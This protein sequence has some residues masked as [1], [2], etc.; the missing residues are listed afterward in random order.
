MPGHDDGDRSDNEN[1]D[2]LRLGMGIHKD[3]A[4]GCAIRGLEVSVQ[5]N[6]RSS[7]VWS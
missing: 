1:V 6:G 7:G 3:A 4:A 2:T 5:Q